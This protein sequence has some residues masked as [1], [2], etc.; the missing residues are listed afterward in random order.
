MAGQGVVAG[1]ILLSVIAIGVVASLRNR[2][3][4]VL[5]LVALF[6][7]AAPVIPVS[8]EM[9]RRYVVMPWLCLSIA[10]VAGVETTFRRRRALRRFC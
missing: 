9:Q 7:A 2:R 8:K 6:L 5:F 1:A 3:A 10:F 4:I